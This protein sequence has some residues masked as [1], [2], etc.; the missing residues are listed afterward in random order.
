MAMQEH[1]MDSICR[2][3]GPLECRYYLY[4]ITYDT[5]KIELKSLVHTIRID[6]E[7]LQLKPGSMAKVT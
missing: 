3:L 2:T 6:F 7:A 5:R 1:L 4:Y